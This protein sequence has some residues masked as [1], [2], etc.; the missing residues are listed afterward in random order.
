MVV[1]SGTVVVV[2]WTVVVVGCS[3]MVDVVV[4]T[5]AD[6]STAEVSTGEVWATVVS[7]E[8]ALESP[9]CATS[10]SM[11]RP[12]NARTSSGNPRGMGMR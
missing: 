6:V 11:P 4:M 2:G 9:H 1:G 8:S 7:G 10:T 12:A 5:G 3:T